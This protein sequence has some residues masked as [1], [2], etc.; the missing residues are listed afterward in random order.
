MH[1][2]HAM[3]GYQNYRGHPN[4]HK[5]MV[6][7]GGYGHGYGGYGHPGAGYP[8]A[9]Y[10]AVPGHHPYHHNVPYGELHDGYAKGYAYNV[11]PIRAITKRGD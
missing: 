3:H 9:G 5:N 11:S 4:H 7:Y 2:P 6:G 1:G 10:G 8:G